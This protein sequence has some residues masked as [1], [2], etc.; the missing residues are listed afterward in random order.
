MEGAV[1]PVSIM[2]RLCQNRDRG[3]IAGQCYHDRTIPGQKCIRMNGAGDMNLIDKGVN[4]DRCAWAEKGR[5]G[6][7]IC[8]LT[9]DPDTGKQ[10]PFVKECL[11]PDITECEAF[12]PIIKHD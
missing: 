12:M 7:V 5:N 10:Y 4:M 9:F 11:Y 2:M 1:E 3:G 8:K 6:I